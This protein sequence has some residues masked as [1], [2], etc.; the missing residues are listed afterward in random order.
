MAPSL[1]KHQRIL[2]AEDEF[3][4]GLMLEENLRDSGWDV[5][6]PM[7]SLSD[8]Q[9]A[10][11]AEQFDVAVLDVNLNGSMVFPALETIRQP[12]ILVTGYGQQAIQRGAKVAAVLAK[13]YDYEV[14][15]ILIRDCLRKESG[16][17][18]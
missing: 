17:G 3:L 4:V 2:V 9:Q 18:G 1:A 8:L 14:L 13:P 10:V 16:R 15:E 5:V 11:A 7:A 6:G 12:V